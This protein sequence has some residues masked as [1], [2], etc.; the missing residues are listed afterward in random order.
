MKNILKRFS[1]F[2]KARWLRLL[3]G[4]ALLVAVAF[5][6]AQYQTSS[7]LAT[8][9]G[10]LAVSN[11]TM[12]QEMSAQNVTVAQLNQDKSDLEDRLAQA[13]Q[14]LQQSVPLYEVL[15]CTDMAPDAVPP[16][17]TGVVQLVVQGVA[18]YGTEV[19]PS[20]MCINFLS[21][22][23]SPLTGELSVYASREFP[24]GAEDRFVVY[25]GPVPGQDGY[26]WITGIYNVVT[27]EGVPITHEPQ[28]EEPPSGNP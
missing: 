3:I 24:G 6:V 16:E 28:T 21:I 11:A 1:V 17:F 20:R 23:T 25:I 14:L 7:I 12:T 27:H 4:A 13:G 10:K 19:K 22:H 8:A 18:G 9:V 5:N 2:L 26:I 15:W